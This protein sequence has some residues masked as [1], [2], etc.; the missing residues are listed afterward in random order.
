MNDEFTGPK[1]DLRCNETYDNC[2][3]CDRSNICSECIFKEFYGPFCND[4]CANCPGEIEKCDINGICD[5]NHTEC[6][7]NTFRGEKCDTPCNNNTEIYDNCR[8]CTRDNTCLECFNRT[9]YGDECKDECFQCP[10]D[11]GYCYIN[12]T[13]ED[14]TGICDD[15]TLTGPFCNVSCNVTYNNCL[16]CYRDNICF[17]CIN[18]TF[19]GPYCNYS[20]ANCPGSPGYCDNEGICYNSEDLCDDD[21]FTGANCSVPCNQAKENCKRCD[22]NNT[23]LECFDQEMFGPDC[24]TS[25]ANCPGN[26]TCDIDGICEDQTS[27]CD[28]DTLT[29]PKCDTPCKEEYGNCLRCDRDNICHECINREFYGPFC[30]DSCKNCPGEKG[31]CYNNGTCENKIDNCDDD[32]LTGP[33]CDTPCNDT[34]KNCYRCD[35]KNVCL[36]CINKNKYGNF[37]NDSCA[38]C[39]G[40]IEKCNITGICYD[41]VTECVDNTL[42]GEKC[43]TPCNNDTKIYDNCRNCT[44][45]NTCIECINKESYG[46]FCNISCAN[47]PGNCSINGICIDQNSDC[48]DDSFKGEACQTPCGNC[49]RCHRNNS[50]IECFDQ[51]YHGENCSTICSGCSETGCDIQGYCREFKCRHGTY[52]LKC[53]TDCTCRQNSNSIECGKYEG[54]CISCKFG[55][56]GKDCDQYCNYKCQSELCCLFKDHTR[57]IKSKFEFTSDYRYVNI[58]YEGQTYKVE[59][60]YNYG[61]PMTLFNYEGKLLLGKDKEEDQV[62]LNFTN[63]IA[64]GTL[65]KGKSIT[66]DDKEIKNIHLV[67][68]DNKSV[69]YKSEKDDSIKGVIGLGFFNSISNTYFPGEDRSAIQLNI[70]SYALDGNDISML[71]GNMHK[72]EIDYVDKLTSC[73]VIL[74]NSTEIQGKKMTCQLDGIKS[75]KHTDAFRLKNAYI[76]FSL[77]EKSSLILGN[78]IKYKEYLEKVYF[79]DEAEFVDGSLHNS[80]ISYFLYPDDKINRLSDFGFVFNSYYYSYKPTKFFPDSSIGGKKKFLIE[81]RND[82]EKTE[83]VIGKE[84]LENFKFTINNEEAK[85][86]F[87]AKNAMFS[88]EFTDEVQPEGFNIKLAAN[89]ISLICLAIIIFLN[90][91]AFGAYFFFKKRKMNNNNY[92][93]V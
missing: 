77:A 63:Y 31:L 38:N 51:R 53:D 32:R 41:Q 18:E 9:Y 62:I 20:C 22:R 73:E 24:N 61:Y 30:N 79:R 89:E 36:E 4:S 92:I 8:N 85:I 33:K 42:R 66:I 64:N 69:E 65:L 3:R 15:D 71:F 25:C 91:V 47:C 58:G 49:K 43:D 74:D 39:P 7:D 27:N 5:D 93:S 44:R 75:S 70:L 72:D 57:N 6:V 2:F 23:C 76:T 54:Q 83:F 35:R 28:D 1:C 55:Y 67:I 10:G 21:I 19:F 26:G 11:P 78:N 50:C 56:Y 34:Y 80:T 16:S 68:S 14:E 60:D 87:Y 45:N 81:I 13:C 37:C 86:Y 40:E 84:F 46:D 17:K 52:G 59:I 82:T 88:D 29:G 48:D 90:F 12:G